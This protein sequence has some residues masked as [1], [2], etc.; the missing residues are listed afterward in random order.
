[1]SRGD[2]KRQCD[3]L[4]GESAQ[5]FPRRDFS[6]IIRPLAIGKSF[7]RWIQISLVIGSRGNSVRCCTII[8]VMKTI[9]RFWMTVIDTWRNIQLLILSRCCCWTAIAAHWCPMQSYRSYWWSWW[10]IRCAAGRRIVRLSRIAAC[11]G[12]NQL[13]LLLDCVVL[14]GVLISSLDQG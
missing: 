14:I 12:R 4:R 3:D 1:M 13:L 8:G 10:R 11:H 6:N 5:R 7:S 9:R 2:S